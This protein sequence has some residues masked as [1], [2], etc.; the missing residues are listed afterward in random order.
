ML[1]PLQG[2]AALDSQEELALEMECAICYSQY[3]NAFHAPKVLQCQH[4]F[5]LECLARINVKSQ[6]PDTIQCPMCRSYTRLPDSGPPK[7]DNNLAIL[8]C[9]PK[10]MN[11]T[12][13]IHFSRSKGR[14]WLK[15]LPEVSH[16]TVVPQIFM[17]NI[18]HSL[19]VGRPPWQENQLHQEDQWSRWSCLDKPLC[20]TLLVVAVMVTVTLIISST[21]FFIL[22]PSSRASHNMTALSPLVATDSSP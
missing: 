8:S 13:S 4:T 1:A 7:L 12:C 22:P 21:L 6:L 20:R 5:C 16:G 9:L 10:G 18:S 19:D 14:L 15:Q 2:P 11:R 17:S 3:N